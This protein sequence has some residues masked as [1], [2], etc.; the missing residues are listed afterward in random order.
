MLTGCAQGGR[1]PDPVAEQA[2]GGVLALLDAD[3]SGRVEPAE[4][5]R[6][7]QP[8]SPAFATLDRD[9]SGGLDMAELVGLI[10]GQNPSTF[11]PNFIP[12]TQNPLAEARPDPTAEWEVRVV[13]NFYL[14]ELEEVHRRDPTLPIPS[15]VDIAAALQSGDVHS[16]PSLDMLVKVVAACRATGVGVPPEVH[17]IFASM[18]VA[19][20]PTSHPGPG[21]AVAPGPASPRPGRAG[22]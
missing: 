13:R 11:Q 1:A 10:A 15:E 2:F 4:Y 8:G 16:P 17:T 19:I 21:P 9:G 12:M 18:P 20:L 5:T 22:P 14:F 6:V 7:A 3:R